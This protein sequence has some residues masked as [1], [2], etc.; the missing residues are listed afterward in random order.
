MCPRW[1]ELSVTVQLPVART[2]RHGLP[3]IAPGP[4]VSVAL[5]GVPA[6]AFTK[7]VPGLTFTCSVS[8]CGVPTG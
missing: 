2:V 1:L 3:V 5:T 6:G 7:P 4:D 8:T